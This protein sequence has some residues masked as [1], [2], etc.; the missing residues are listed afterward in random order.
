MDNYPLPVERLEKKKKKEG[1]E[2]KKIKKKIE[3]SLLYLE[4]RIEQEKKRGESVRAHFIAALWKK[5]VIFVVG[6]HEKCK[7]VLDFFSFTTLFSSLSLSLI[8]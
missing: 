1:G 7:F 5:A 2:E 8:F 3:E 4:Q 6:L